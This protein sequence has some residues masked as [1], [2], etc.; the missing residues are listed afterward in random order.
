MKK[1]MMA[2]ALLCVFGGAL[3]LAAQ[4]NAVSPPANPRS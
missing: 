3:P 1:L 4:D 2:L